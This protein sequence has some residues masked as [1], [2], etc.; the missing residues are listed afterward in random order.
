MI[1]SSFLNFCL[2]LSLRRLFDTGPEDRTFEQ[3]V[4]RL[5]IDLGPVDAIV[6]SHGHFDHGGAM[7]RALQ[8]ISDRNGG[9]EVAYYAHPDMFRTRA[10]KQ[11]N[12]AMR[13]LEDVP[14]I[15]ALEAHGAKVVNTREPQFLFDGTVYVSGE[16]PRVTPFERGLPGQHRQTLDGKGWELDE[17][18]M[19]ER[20]VAVNV[21]GKGI[22]IFTACSHAGV[23]N[24]LKHAQSSFP[25]IPLY[26]VLGLSGSNE[27]IIPPTVKAIREFNISV[28]ATGH[29]TG[30]RA[31]NALA[32]A[33]GD[34]R[35]VPLNVGKQ[36]AF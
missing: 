1:V 34:A 21:A 36:F 4:S 13:L 23:V 32:N 31:M 30:W 8:I 9:R 28:I 2:F 12:G 7:L 3:N 18:I 16:I 26:G 25:D 33:F 14:N 11:S 17:L 22:V 5:G 10:Q 6:L 35:L 19:D 20:F 27:R 29:C 15:S 24:V